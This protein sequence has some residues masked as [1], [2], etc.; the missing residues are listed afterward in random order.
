MPKFFTAMNSAPVAIGAGASG[1]LSVFSSAF[2]ITEKPIKVI[3]VDWAVTVDAAGGDLMLQIVGG[4]VG[5][6]F[7][8]ASGVQIQSNTI[9]AAPWTPALIP[10]PLG[11][12]F[13]HPLEQPVIVKKGDSIDGKMFAQIQIAASAS[14][15]NTDGVNPHTAQ[16]FVD[17]EL[18]Y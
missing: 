2:P 7:N 13:G 12:Y 15:H 5:I 10:F 4:Q 8:D 18:D 14:I 6:S 11:S 1:F 3:A 17:F 9:Q 16:L